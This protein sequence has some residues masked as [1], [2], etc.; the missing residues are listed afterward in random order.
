MKLFK[1]RTDAGRRLAER[2]AHCISEPNLLVLGLPRGGIVV[3][4]EIAEALHAPLDVLI[5][6]KLGVPGH[7]E[8]AM[9]AIASGD[10]V[11]LNHS[12][13][14][15][16]NISD[17]T[18][19]KVI[20]REREEMTRREK[21]FRNNRPPPVIP[22]RT[23]ILVDDGL[24]TGATMQAAIEAVKSQCPAYVEVA[25]PVAAHATLK[26]FAQWSTIWSAWPNPI[27]FMV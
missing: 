19:Q 5:V 8:L 15:A 9:G 10:I 20:Q 21:I 23:V 13:I 27:L 22:D 12:V 18:L 7:E 14:D 4:F 16:V 26:N 1:D 24:A 6:R 2:L 3:A 17:D 11:V 25:V